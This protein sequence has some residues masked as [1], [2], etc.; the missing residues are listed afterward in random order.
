MSSEKSGDRS[1]AGQGQAYRSFLLRCWQEAGAK[2]DGK[3][4]WRFTLVD[5]DDAQ[6]QRAF[7]DLEALAAPLRQELE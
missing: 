6:V 4:A 7:A 1:L 3:P 5:F 2:P